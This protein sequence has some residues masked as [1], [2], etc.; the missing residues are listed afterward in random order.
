MDCRVCK[1]ILVAIYG[2]YPRKASPDFGMRKS[3]MGYLSSRIS[4]FR[5]GKF[6][7]SAAKK[8]HSTKSGPLSSFED[9]DPGS[10]NYSPEW[11]GIQNDGWGRNGGEVTFKEY[12]RFGNGKVVVTAHPASLQVNY[13]HF[14]GL[15]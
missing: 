10:W 13:Y 9:R 4:D 7:F 15:N 6:S 12:S 11:W 5:R 3:F 1:P 8:H 14:F 2:P